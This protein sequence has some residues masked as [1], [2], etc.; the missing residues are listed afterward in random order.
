MLQVQDTRLPVLR[1]IPKTT[2]QL[3]F[4]ETPLRIDVSRD[5]IK[6]IRV[7]IRTDA[8]GSPL[9]IQKQ[10]NRTLHLKRV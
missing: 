7:F 5:E 1:V 6:H 9:F 3:F 4:F 10:V 8:M 2:Q